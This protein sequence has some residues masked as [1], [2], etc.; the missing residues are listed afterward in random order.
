M[1]E[2]DYCVDDS[3]KALE[4]IGWALDMVEDLRENF[5]EQY[6]AGEDFITDVESKLVSVEKHIKT[7]GKVTDKQARAIVGWHNGIAK[8]FPED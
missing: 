6:D 1:L 4:A 8:W 2:R 3:E 7:Y 5:P